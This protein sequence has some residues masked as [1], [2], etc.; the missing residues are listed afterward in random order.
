V[1]ENP[2]LQPAAGEAA[3]SL[4]A[5]PDWYAAGAPQPAPPAVAKPL[6]LAKV[7]IAVGAAFSIAVGAG[8]G[9]LIVQHRQAHNDQVLAAARAQ[10][11]EL[12]KPVTAGVRADGSHYGPLFAYLLPMPDGYGPGPGDSTYGNNSYASADQITTQ[13]QDLL[14]GVSKSDLASAKGMLANTHL[15]GLAVR[16]LATGAQ[17]VSVV[18]IELEQFDVKDASKAADNF[19]T[20][21]S[22]VNIFRNGTGV[23]GYPRAKCVLPPGLGSDKVDEMFCVASSGDIE[24]V[25]DAQ[26]VTPIGQPAVAALV[27]QQLDRLKTSQTLS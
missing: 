8:I 17:P 19:D 27:A 25:V 2:G 16:T 9:T 14:S 11:V 7:L 13:L 24:V 23:P 1:S 5:P 20:F 26:G 6:P 3:P 15:K 21:V 22:D 12:P 10:Q 18:S 4:P